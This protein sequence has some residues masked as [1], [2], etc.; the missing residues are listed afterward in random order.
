MK[1]IL[2]L[3]IIATIALLVGCKKNEVT[4]TPDPIVPFE[5]GKTITTTV[6]GKVTAQDG[7]ALNNVEITIGT[8]TTTTDAGG[9]FI[10]PSNTWRK[11]RIY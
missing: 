6:A 10:I 1:K 11:S 9:N 7:T 3:V 2:Q 5:T 8:S 4:T